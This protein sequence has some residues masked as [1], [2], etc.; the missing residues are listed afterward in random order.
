MRD[1][2]QLAG[3]TQLEMAVRLGVDRSYVFDMEN[4]K[5]TEQLRRVFL[6]LRILGMRMTLRHALW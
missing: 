3:M 6:A 4:G 1:A 2:R 5:E